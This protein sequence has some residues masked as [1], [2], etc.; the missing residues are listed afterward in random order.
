MNQGMRWKLPVTTMIMITLALAA[1]SV[2]AD[3]S[4]TAKVNSVRVDSDGRGIV[5]FNSNIITP[6]GCCPDPNICFMNAFAFDTNTTGGKSLFSLAISAQLSGKSVT[7]FGKNSCL[8]YPRG[9]G[10][11]WAEDLS[12]ITMSN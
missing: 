11:G 7:A 9:A 5:F 8:V 3:G 1:F 4:V 6:A 10:Q 12:Y 2:F